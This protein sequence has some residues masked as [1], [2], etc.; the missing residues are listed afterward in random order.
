MIPASPKSCQRRRNEKSVKCR[1][2]ES[3]A[4]YGSGRLKKRMPIRPRFVRH[5]CI[6]PLSWRIGGSSFSGFVCRIVDFRTGQLLNSRSETVHGIV[7]FASG[8][9][10]ELFQL[11]SRCVAN[12]LQEPG[13]KQRQSAVK[14]TIG[15]QTRSCASRVQNPAADFL[16]YDSGTRS[17][18]RRAPVPKA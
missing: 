16:G 6:G 9:R 13:R 14:R 1:C 15:R 2:Q 4:N 10:K 7:D 12:R 5:F 11:A 18:A 17:P 3:W 8:V